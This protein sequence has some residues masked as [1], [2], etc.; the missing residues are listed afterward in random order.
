[1]I[2]PIVRLFLSQ[3]WYFFQSH[4]SGASFVQEI[5]AFRMPFSLKIFVL[6]AGKTAIM[7]TFITYCQ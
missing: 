5:I 7:L 6:S 1:M 3:W 2:N 4:L